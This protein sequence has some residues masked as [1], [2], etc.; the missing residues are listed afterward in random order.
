MEYRVVQLQPGINYFFRA[1]A[2]SSKLELW[3]KWSPETK[4]KT[5]GDLHPRTDWD[6][7][8]KS[9]LDIKREKSKAKKKRKRKNNAAERQKEA[10]ERQK[11]SKRRRGNDEKKKAEIR[12]RKETEGT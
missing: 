10:E 5:R 2:Y 12:R 11:G 6:Q 9:N 7:P 1:R 4:V 3:G 8:L